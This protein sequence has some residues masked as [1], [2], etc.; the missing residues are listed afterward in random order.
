MN[1]IDPLESRLREEAHRDP[2]SPSPHLRTRI[3]AEV[4]SI[5]ADQAMKRSSRWVA[6][7]SGTVA[8]LCMVVVGVHRMANQASDPGLALAQIG[9]WHEVTERAAAVSNRLSLVVAEPFEDEVQALA[10]D[11]ERAR[12]FLAACMPL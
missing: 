3:M 2:S 9:G 10:S 5:H 7:A 8:I 1:T 12:K 11:A 4:T 6:Y